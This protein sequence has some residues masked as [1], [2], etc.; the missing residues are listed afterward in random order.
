MARSPDLKSYK[1]PADDCSFVEPPSAASQENPPVYPHNNITVSKSGHV[2]EFDDTP[3]GERVRLKHRSGTFIEMH[4]D[5]DEVH[6][7]YGDGYEITVKNKNVYIGG[8]CNI[9]IKGDACVNYEGNR[10]EIVAKDYS[11]VVKGDYTVSCKQ[12]IGLYSKDDMTL[13]GGDLLGGSINLIT[14]DHLHLNGDLQV[15]GHI[16]ALSVGAE[17]M[18]ASKGLSAGTSGVFS[19]GPIISLISV[20]APFGTWGMSKSIWHSDLI[21]TLIAKIHIHMT[22]KG[23]TSVETPAPLSA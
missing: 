6:K 4:P 12:E 14:G 1:K 17:R 2:L 9:T 19:V 10:K 23:P 20:T 16:D 18:D 3:K 13:A 21:N 8:I 15:S 22:P 11:L 7:V 5:G